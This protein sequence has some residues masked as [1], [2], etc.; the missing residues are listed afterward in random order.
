[1]L[2]IFDG[3]IMRYAVIDGAVS[4]RLAVSVAC[5]IANG[6]HVVSTWRKIPTP[7]IGSPRGKVVSITFSESR[8]RNDVDASIQ[9]PDGLT[10]HLCMRKPLGAL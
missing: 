4:Y 8:T 10:L 9:R 5:S 7:V 3:K 6:L 1:M 2:E